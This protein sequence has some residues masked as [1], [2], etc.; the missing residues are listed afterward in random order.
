MR[1]T[2]TDISIAYLHEC[3]HRD[4]ETDALT[5]KH[6]PREHFVSD[7]DW[8]W[9]NRRF[10]GKSAGATHSAGYLVIG[11]KIGSARRRQLKVQRIVFALANGRW[12]IDRLDHEDRNR[13]NNKIGNLREATDSQNMQNR[14]LDSRNQSGVTGVSFHKSSSKWRA[15]IQV[16]GH[17]RYLSGFDT[18]KDACIARFDAEIELHPFRAK[19]KPLDPKTIIPD[20]VIV[21]GVWRFATKPKLTTFTYV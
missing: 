12:P 19:P 15:D 20:H 13:A 18:F 6:R 10:A 2:D 14:S 4:P 5:W 7:R 16:D 1:P 11:I 3:F 17:R 9:W 8:R 21:T